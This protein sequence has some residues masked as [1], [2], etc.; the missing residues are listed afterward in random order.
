VLLAIILIGG[1]LAALRYHNAPWP[2]QEPP[3][4]GTDP[5]TFGDVTELL[6]VPLTLAVVA[7]VFSTYQRRQDREIAAEE[8]KNDREIARDRNEETELQ[9]YFDRMSELMLMHD[10]YTPSDYNHIPP[11]IARARTLAVLRSIQSPVR[12]ASVVRFLYESGLIILPFFA[13]IEGMKE[14]EILVIEGA[15]LR[16]VEL[17]DTFLQGVNLSKTKLHKADLTGANLFG[18]NLSGTNLSGAGL[19]EAILKKANLSEAYLSGAF[20]FVADLTNANLHKASMIDTDLYEANMS[21]AALTDAHLQRAELYGANLEGANL[22][23]AV[24][25]GAKID[26]NTNFNHVRYNNKTIPPP[27]GFP[28]SAINVDEEEDKQG[29]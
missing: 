1:T 10:L 27:G 17:S 28:D 11:T 19:S 23:G 18:A 7:Y 12:K 22:Q 16:E 21:G 13:K 20:L 29:E 2:W 4:A 8:R 9:T 14:R 3:P 25:K 6:I 15:D 24:L 26:K 5:L